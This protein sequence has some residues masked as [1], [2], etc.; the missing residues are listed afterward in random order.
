[1]W[2]ICPNDFLLRT[3]RYLSKEERGIL[4]RHLQRLAIDWPVIT[5]HI[6]DW[7]SLCI[8]ADRKQKRAKYNPTGKKKL[9]V[10]VER[11]APLPFPDGMWFV[12][13]L[14]HTVEN[15]LYMDVRRWDEHTNKESSVYGPSPDGI[16]LPFEQ[17][18]QLFGTSFKLLT[19]W[20]KRK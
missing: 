3:I 5:N 1:M 19:K 11:S 6:L 12:R 4:H 15:R 13:V 14:F 10:L 7:D 8:L 17:F 16:L 2:A 9:W 20:E 18:Q